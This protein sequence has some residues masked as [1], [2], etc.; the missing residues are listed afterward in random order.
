MTQA[1][2]EDVMEVPTRFSLFLAKPGTSPV[3]ATLEK[4]TAEGAMVIIP[5]D[6]PKL[7]IALSNPIELWISDGPSGAS[8][9]VPAV[10]AAR[11]DADG[12]SVFTL[13][14][15]DPGAVE[16]LLNKD[17]V[18]LFDR[19]QAFRAIPTDGK[20]I[21]LTVEAPEDA[22]VPPVHTWL[23]DISTTGLAFDVPVGFESEM[24]L[25]DEVTLHF[26]LPGSTWPQVLVGVIRNRS[27][28]N[29]NRVRYG[30]QFNADKT[31]RYDLQNE[32][33]TDYVIARQRAMNAG[34]K[35]DP[36]VVPSFDMRTLPEG[37]RP[38]PTEPASE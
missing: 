24:I 19:R 25:F 1:V 35:A 28:A 29:P 18:K 14:F 30:V 10:A 27:W 8:V 11:D 7:E 5:K 6:S 13:E 38:K 36:P 26:L 20:S 37:L 33:I 2:P 32:Q 17:L 12:K 22:G 4:I 31:I 23:V 21:A 9:V 15:T 16:S 3:P 34:R